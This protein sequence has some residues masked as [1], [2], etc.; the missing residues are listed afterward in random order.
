MESF[1]SSPSKLI[2]ESISFFYIPHSAF[3]LCSPFYPAL[4]FV[5]AS[6]LFFQIIDDL[7]PSEIITD[8][9]Y[10]LPGQSKWSMTQKFRHY[11]SRADRHILTI[12]G[13][14]TYA[15]TDCALPSS[16]QIDLTYAM[17]RRRTEL[18]VY[19]LTQNSFLVPASDYISTDS[20][21]ILTPFSFRSPSPEL[22]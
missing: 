18:V 2:R 6:Q 12:N 9:S 15:Q 21:A 20:K 7:S 14:R 4:K 16:D 8:S 1:F 17:R 19:T 11:P 22:Q 3:T 5:E 10:T 13:P